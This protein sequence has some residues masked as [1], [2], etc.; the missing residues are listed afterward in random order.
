[1]MNKTVFFILCWIF[2]GFQL[3]AQEADSLKDHTKD[4]WYLL[5]PKID[6]VAGISLDKAYQHLTGRTGQ[7]VVVAIIDSGFDTAHVD[8]KTNMWVN[9]GE[10]PGNGLDDDG[11]GLVD[12][13]HGWNYLGNQSGENV[14]GET[15]EMTR[16]YR[17]LKPVYSRLKPSMIAEDQKE[18]Y[19]LYL[20]VK[21]A[22][23]KEFD[24][25][26]DHLKMYQNLLENYNQT[27]VI[28]GRYLNNQEFTRSDVAAIKTR[29]ERVIRAKN[30]YLLISAMEWNQET[31]TAM[32]EHCKSI[33]NTKL[34]L[35][36]DPRHILGDDPLNL[37]DS[38]YG[39]NDLDGTT[40]GHGTSVAGVVAAIRHNGFGINGIADLA[41]IMI[42]RVV[43]GGDEY[44]KD[45]ARAIFYAVNNGARVINCSFGKDFSPQKWMVDAAVKYAE[46]HGVVIVHAAGNDGKNNDDGNNFPTPY[47]DD[48][49]RASNW[50]EVGASTKHINKNLPASFSNYGLQ[51][52]DLFAPGEEIMSLRPGS[53]YESASGTSLAA[54]VVTGVVA[55]LL[56]YYPDLTAADVRTIIMDSATPYGK[57]K[58]IIPGSS[59]KTR[60]KNLCVSG[61][62]LNAY[63]AVIMAENVTPIH[64]RP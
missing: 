33:L 46:A 42:I 64:K 16:L 36:H 30:F 41:E 58:V 29:D 57:K 22:W 9:P 45:V 11:N 13:V 47:Y 60:M 19:A 48:G 21:E 5:D 23:Q 56:S 32:V 51:R 24:N 44:D 61:G 1:M 20:R 54:P 35:D 31:L 34:N 62:V 38:I 14:A 17:Q 37:N 8:I 10:I 40:A 49:G 59:K 18:E 15:L 63:N 6:K 27:V 26:Q 3:A 7:K 52:V 55:L 4:Q 39:N 25:A 53:R 2:F 50:I 12:D 28:L 43:P